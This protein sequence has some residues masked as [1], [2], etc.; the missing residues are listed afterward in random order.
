MRARRPSGVASRPF[1]GFIVIAVLAIGR[2]A[3]AG[4]GWSVD[5][6]GYT[7]TNATPV[8]SEGTLQEG[9]ATSAFKTWDATSSGYLKPCDG[10]DLTLDQSIKLSATGF[11]DYGILKATVMAT[12]LNLPASVD[13]GQ[14]SLVNQFDGRGEA[15]SGGGFDDVIMVDSPTLPPGTPVEVDFTTTIDAIVGA[16]DGDPGDGSGGAGTTYLYFSSGLF[17]YGFPP[18]L[19]QG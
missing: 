11:A 16:E 10:Q 12:A 15:N 17:L 4:T 6:T 1:A 9:T 18:E 3:Q 5:V 19:G 13:C 8:T 2:L 14:G 7:D